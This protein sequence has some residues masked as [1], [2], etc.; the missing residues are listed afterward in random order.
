[1]IQ[2]YITIGG[3]SSEEILINK[4]RFIAYASP[5]KT[6]EEALSFLRDIR[7]KHKNATHHCYAY[8]IGTNASIM[9]YSDNGEPAG[10]AGLPIM[11]VMR[12][13]GIVNCCIVVV[14]YFGG[15][16]LGTGGLV[17]AYT[18]SGQAAVEAAGIARMELT[19][20]EYCELPYSFWDRF[21]HASE[22]LPVRIDRISYGSNVSFHLLVRSSDRDRVLGSLMDI[23]A[24]NLS[25]ATEN[26]SYQPWRL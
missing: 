9:R 26:E 5:C 24:R 18:Q 25:A 17:R 11:D 10:T 1:M 6:E 13:K 21:R 22:Q 16:L 8:V 14:R 12:A 3:C 7:E 4:S 23:T 19:S 20:D 15:V 2:S